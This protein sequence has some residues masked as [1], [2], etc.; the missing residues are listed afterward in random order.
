[1]S[2]DSHALRA[3]P[4]RA[5]VGTGGGDDWQVAG[6]SMTIVGNWAGVFEPFPEIATL[7]DVTL[8][9]MP[10]GSLSGFGV[11]SIVGGETSVPFT[12]E[13]GS[14][15]YSS[16]TFVIND[17][18]NELEYSATLARDGSIMNGCVYG[19]GASGVVLELERQ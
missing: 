18:Q 19:P 17:G 14:L 2:G 9:E 13:A 5:S 1:M 10:D 4:R 3:A 8:S 16:V 6:G 7:L 11:L 12:V 15:D